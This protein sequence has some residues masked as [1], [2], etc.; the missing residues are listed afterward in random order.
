MQKTEQLWISLK[1][2]FALPVAQQSD[3][4]AHLTEQTVIQS[5][6]T[7][8]HLTQAPADNNASPSLPINRELRARLQARFLSLYIGGRSFSPS[9]L[10]PRLLSY[11]NAETND[12]SKL[13][14]DAL[15]SGIIETYSVNTGLPVTAVTLHRHASNALLRRIN[16][17]MGISVTADDLDDMLTAAWALAECTYLDRIGIDNED[18]QRYWKLL[19]DI[20]QRYRPSSMIPLIQRHWTR[21]LFYIGMI[22]GAKAISGSVGAITEPDQASFFESYAQLTLE[23]LGEANNVSG[24]DSSTLPRSHLLKLLNKLSQLIALVKRLHL[25][26]CTATPFP[27]RMLDINTFRNS[28]LY[29]HEGNT[30]CTLAY[31]FNNPQDEAE[32]QASTV[33]VLEISQ[34]I[35]SLYSLCPALELDEIYQLQLDVARND[36]KSA[37]DD[38]CMLIPRLL[39]PY[40]GLS[41]VISSVLLLHFASNYYRKF[42]HGEH[43]RWCEKVVN[44]VREKYGVCVRL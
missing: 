24:A 1:Q 40:Q 12:V 23:L 44:A 9:R 22:A 21:Q 34:S 42:D 17:T 29:H 15:C 20:A 30:L 16:T 36:A 7:Q 37:A 18:L 41:S 33:C 26:W 43:L 35:I 11:P 27:F 31:H 32:F 6:Q 14:I 39:E 2:T 19:I 10:P 25:Q 13:A 28:R 8:V 5:P 4:P 38:I 3:C